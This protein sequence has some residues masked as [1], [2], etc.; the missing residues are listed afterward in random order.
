MDAMLLFI[1]SCFVLFLLCL[2]GYVNKQFYIIEAGTKNEQA[3]SR[4]TGPRICLS[5]TSEDSSLK[6]T[7]TPVH[8]HRPVMATRTGHVDGTLFIPSCFLLFLFRLPGYVN[9]QFYINE[10]GTKDARP[11]PQIYD[12][13][14][15]RVTSMAL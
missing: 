7:S 6:H 2:R 10:K 15:D 13:D 8:H 14:E 11:S 5:P 1:H 4:T 12:D 9:K 3:A